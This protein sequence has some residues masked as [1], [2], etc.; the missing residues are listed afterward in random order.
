MEVLALYEKASHSGS[1]NDAVRDA[2]RC[3]DF[4]K[5]SLLHSCTEAAVVVVVIGAIVPNAPA[6]L[7]YLSGLQ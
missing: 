6:L 3:Q 2:I 1:D 5:Q 7:S 4:L